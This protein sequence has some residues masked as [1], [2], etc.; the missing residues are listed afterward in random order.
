MKFNFND[1]KTINLSNKFCPLKIF[2]NLMFKSTNPQRNL[3]KVLLREITHCT[4]IVEY[5]PISRTV[6]VDDVKQYE[7]RLNIQMLPNI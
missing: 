6:N 4:V 5:K 1:P 7:V 2:V 3:R